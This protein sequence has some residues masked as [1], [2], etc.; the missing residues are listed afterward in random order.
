MLCKFLMLYRSPSQ[1][2]DEFESFLKDFESSL[3][4]ITQN[5]PFLVIALGDFNPKSLNW[6]DNDQT[7][8]DISQIALLHRSFI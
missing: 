7:S 3:K 6:D 1:S 2:L 5:N 8:F 4:V